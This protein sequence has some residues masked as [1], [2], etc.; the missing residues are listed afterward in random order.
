M[1][2][3]KPNDKSKISRCLVCAHPMPEAVLLCFHLIADPLSLS[4]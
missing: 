4:I 3:G 2:N 1:I